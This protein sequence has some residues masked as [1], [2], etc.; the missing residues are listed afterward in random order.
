MQTCR[1]VS[2][3][4]T[5]SETKPPP[6]AI[7]T[8]KNIK[9]D[10][11][12]ATGRYHCRTTSQGMLAET[13]LPSKPDNSRPMEARHSSHKILP[14]RQRFRSK[15]CGQGECTAPIRNCAALLQMIMRLE[16]RA[17]LW[18]YFLMGL[19]G[20]KGPRLD[21][22]V[23]YQSPHPFSASPT[24]QESGSTLLAG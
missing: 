15:V 13:W 23:C 20:Q 19:R 7:S 8:E 6:T 1:T 18:T 9:G 12:P 14:G 5:T 17:I 24:C 21:A 2:S 3:S 4:A 11:W 10:V 16:G 22:R